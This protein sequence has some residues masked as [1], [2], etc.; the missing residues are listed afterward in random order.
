MTDRGQPGIFA[1]MQQRRLGRYRICLSRSKSQN[2]DVLIELYDLI[3]RY[4][5]GGSLFVSVEWS[6]P[7]DNKIP[8]GCQNPFNE[9]LRTRGPITGAFYT[10]PFIYSNNGEP[11]DENV[12]Q[13][14]GEFLRRAV[15]LLQGRPQTD[16]GRIGTLS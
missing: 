15:P 2:P 12:D 4:T 14:L 1:A 5:E 11:L 6:G 8:T 9:F 13:S 3:F 10:H 16:G 7:R